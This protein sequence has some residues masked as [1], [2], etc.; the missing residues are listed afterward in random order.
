MKT[1]VVTGACGGMGR[2]AVFALVSS[3][4]RVIALDKKEAEMP[5]GVIY[6]NTDITNA[7]SIKE[8]AEKISERTDEIYAVIHF[9]G[10]YMLDS[11]VEID[12]CGLRKIFDVNLFGAITL[13]KALLPK[14]KSGSRILVTTSELAPLA[15]LPFTGIYAVTKAALDK[16]AYSLAMELRLLDISVSVLRAGAVNTDMLGVSTSALDR[17][18]E[19]TKLYTCNADRFK[20]IVNG[21]EARSIP[22]ETLAEKVV[23][24][25]QKRK[26][27]FTYSINRNPFLLILNAFPKSFQLWIIEK[28]LK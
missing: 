6:I 16:Y 8:A 21:V 22:A 2:A 9:A 27:K 3:G 15:P 10:I 20:K 23:K 7:E 5:E 14:L 24:I 28:I 25:L 26:P 19:K 4:Y 11:F 1:V 12:E 13:N 17:F 18:C